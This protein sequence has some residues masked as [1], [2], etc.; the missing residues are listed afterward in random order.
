MLLRSLLSLSASLGLALAASGALAAGPAAIKVA[1]DAT[2]PP[3]EYVQSD[4]MTGFDIE[5]VDAIAAASGLK[6]EWV[7]IDFKGLIP[8]LIAHRADMAASAIYITPPRQQVVDFS[9]PYYAGGLVAL[10]KRS[11]AAIAKPADL[12]GKQVT[13]QVGTKSVSFLQQNYPKAHEVQVEKNDEMFNLVEIGRA[14]AAVTGKPAALLYAKTHPDM[15]VLPESLTHEEYGF[16]IRKDEPDLLKTVNAG[17]QK[18][19]ADGTYNK[20]VSK[21]F[22]QE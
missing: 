3:F 9:E 13:V 10:V 6:V 22:G 21:W 11:N 17:L 8:A 5:L 1:T 7:N 20:L 19:K 15:K 2:F 16:A 4:K 12:A 14:D 18:V